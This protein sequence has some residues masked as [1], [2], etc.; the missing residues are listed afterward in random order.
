[1]A[2]PTDPE[3]VPVTERDWVKSL[4]FAAS[5]LPPEKRAEFLDKACFGRPGAR[6]E[7]EDLLQ[8]VEEDLPPPSVV[9]EFAP[10]EIIGGRF[11]LVRK[12]GEGGMG[13][14][15]EATDVEMEQVSPQ[16]P[17]LRVALKIIRPELSGV[18]GVELQFRRELLLSRKVQHRNVCR[19]HDLGRHLHDDGGTTL[20][21]TMDF[22]EGMTLAE[23]LKGPKLARHSAYSMVRELLDG[24]EEVHKTGVV[25]RDLKPGNLYLAT[26]EHGDV[27]LVV[28]DFGLARTLQAGGPTITRMMA[29]TPG[30]TAPEQ[31]E[32]GECSVPADIYSLGVILFEMAV[33]GR[34][35]PVNARAYLAAHAPEWAGIIL[36]CLERDPRKRPQSVAEVRAAF[37]AP[38]RFRF[39]SRRLLVWGGTAAVLFAAIWRA[40]FSGVGMPEVTRITFDRSLATDPSFTAS[41][42]YMA[43]ISDREPNGVF[44]VWLRDMADHSDRRLTA[45]DAPATTPNI[46]ADGKWVAY[47]SERNGGG[48]YLVSTQGGEERLLGKDGRHPVIS[49]D[50][51]QIVYWTGQEGDYSTPTGQLWVV[52]IT[53]RERRRLHT[54]FVDAR[55]PVWS[56]DGQ[57]VL[58]RGSR[59]SSVLWN[60]SA[61][62]W[63]S[64][65][66]DD[67]GAVSTG[68]YAVLRSAGLSVHESRIFWSED[69]LL[70]GG[71][72]GHSTNLWALPVSG[73]FARVAGTPQALT[74]GTE[75]ESVPWLLADGGV[76]YA[77]R[78]TLVHI[79]RIPLI[80][81][82]AG[83]VEFVSQDDALDSRPTISASG[84][85]ILFTR[86]LGDARNVMK[87]DMDTGTLRSLLR[88]RPAVPYISPDGRQVV[89]SMPLAERNPIYMLNASGG[90]SRVVCED[91]GEAA[92]WMPD[93]R[94]ILFLTG[95]AGSVRGLEVL[96][97]STGARRVLIAPV[98]GLAEA[99]VSTQ[100]VIAFALR[101]GGGVVSRIYAAPIPPDGPVF[102][103]TWTAWTASTGW[104]DKPR[105]A[106][107]G[108]KLYFLSERDGF[109]CVWRLT[110]P[111]SGAP[112]PIPEEVFHN[113]AGSRDLHYLSRPAQ[114]LGVSAGALVLSVPQM[115][116]NIWIIR[117]RARD[118]WAMSSLVRFF[119]PLPQN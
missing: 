117:R 45:S 110:P 36:R 1:M 66:A 37:P 42:R 74:T 3:E 64:D 69:R 106:P 116:G 82:K 27:R 102:Q 61:D 88:D 7:I 29:G 53:G 71:R 76:A 99:S 24:L 19:M 85:Q 26:G 104:A 40:P 5:E 56:A 57:R 78:R 67:R 108:K 109:V 111:P 101:S 62:W 14:V 95:T 87:K 6:A 86:R 77:H 38:R 25:H 35:D 63:V 103:S 54:E 96:D 100:G 18:P 50:G 97:P 112:L 22:L 34:Y 2:L 41:G 58:F 52:D 44:T 98:A 70:F 89:Y 92:G 65:V 30:Y 72:S 93:S 39:P 114:G 80:N 28:T 11:R 48:V 115:S 20:F 90:E 9:R 105:W 43:F 55:F 107:D 75:T 59:D 73:K 23:R 119:L 13:Q 21:L 83:P 113:H 33:G 4:L 10:G 68:A 47:R 94:G 51:R 46:S 91:C 15:Y 17:E 8:Y 79:V 84:G 12:V 81:D 16:G 118:R 49:P 32:T 60:E 31:F